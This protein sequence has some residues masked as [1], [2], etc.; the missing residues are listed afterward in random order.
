[1]LVIVGLVPPLLLP[2]VIVPV[3]DDK[4]TSTPAESAVALEGVPSPLIE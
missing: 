3:P 1:M 4:N 2:M